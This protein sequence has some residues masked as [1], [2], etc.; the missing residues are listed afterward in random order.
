MARWLVILLA[1]G[2]IVATGALAETEQMKT[3]K[4]DY[5]TLSEDLLNNPGELGEIEN[6]VYQKDVA[7]ITFTKGRM[8]LGRIV[9]GR[10]TTAI[11]IGEGHCSIEVPV[12]SERN[13]MHA[14]TGRESVDEDFEVCFIEFSDNLDLLLKENFEFTPQ[15]LSWKNFAAA[16]QAQGEV[17]FKPSIYHTYDN[18]FQLL[19]S[20]YERKDDGYL[21]ID[22]N[23][24]TFTFDPNRPEQ[25]RIGYEFEGG[26]VIISE[27]AVF[28]RQEHNHYQDSLLSQIQY[29]TRA[30]SKHGELVLGGLDGKKIEEDSRGDMS[31]VVESDSLKYVSIWLNYNLKEDSIYVNGEPADYHRRKDFEHI[32]LILPEYAH[33]G[34]TINVSIWY[35]G[36]DYD[37]ALPYVQS[38]N[39]CLHTFSFAVPGGANYYMPGK[40]P[41]TDGERG[42]DIFEVSP[43]NL[44]NRFYFTGFVTGV[45]TVTATTDA[46]LMMNFVKLKS[47]NKQ[48]MECFIPDA[49]YEAIALESMNFF[50]TLLGGNPPGVFGLYVVPE[51]TFVSMPGTMSLPQN[52]CV[53]S[54]TP[55]ALGGFHM[56][57]GYAAARQWFG[58]LMK[59][60][61]H[62]DQWIEPALASY[63]PGLLIERKVDAGHFYSNMLNRRD[64]LLNLDEVN[65]LRPISIGERGVDMLTANKGAWLVHMLRLLMLDLE[66]MSDRAFTRF[67][68]E[69]SFTF[70]NRVFT[71]ND[72]IALAEKH[73]G[74]SLDWFFNYW[75]Y[76]YRIPQFEI[77]WDVTE[78]GGEYIIDATAVTQD[79]GADFRMPVIMRVETADGQSVFVRETLEG[80]QDSFSLGPFTTEPSQ[81][82]FNEFLSVLCKSNVSRQ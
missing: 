20:H 81:L 47:V 34:D 32:G 24:Y 56:Y 13:C 74:E 7:T 3:F 54:G 26:D 31:L 15:S 36:S 78:D 40:A 51:Q 55:A 73:Y 65:R 50:S 49:T 53:T 1:L 16:K 12:P 19:R 58:N 33:K 2:T 5:N 22:F 42:K 59:P 60:S 6:F 11:F 72:F 10:P 66:S 76:D 52:A 29:P 80:T 64:T 71:T 30:I 4:E 70:N 27:A 75:L 57:S 25:V 14:V 63:L 38:P 69:A 62:R 67:L 21:F 23:R 45:D 44:Y 41:K 79:V 8:H 9:D 28:Q 68:F 18:Y 46:G 82:H 77:K 17:F 37:Y 39:P 48:A 35:D 43:Q 61:T